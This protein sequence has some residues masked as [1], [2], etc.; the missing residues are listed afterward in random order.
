MAWH[1]DK[2]YET[3]CTNCGKRIGEHHYETSECP[4]D[5][6]WGDTKF[7]DLPPGCNSP[8]SPA[9]ACQ[10][11]MKCNRCKEFNSYGEPNQKDG[12]YRCYSCR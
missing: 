3:I 11:G 10:S 5:K 4:A 1:T 6:G 8:C 2:D 7:S 12:T 9:Q